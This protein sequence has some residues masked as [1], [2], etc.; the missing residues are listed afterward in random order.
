MNRVAAGGAVTGKSEFPGVFSPPEFKSVGSLRG[1][2]GRLRRRG[3]RRPLRG[4]GRR[5]VHRR[6]PDRRRVWREHRDGGS[7]RDRI[8]QVLRPEGWCARIGGILP[9]GSSEP[10]SHTAGT[11]AAN[12][13]ATA[14]SIS[15]PSPKKVA[16]EGRR[17]GTTSRRCSTTRLPRSYRQDVESERAPSQDVGDGEGWRAIAPT[18]G[19]PMS[20]EISTNM[21]QRPSDGDGAANRAEPVSRNGYFAATEGNLEGGGR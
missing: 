8:A 21:P 15:A 5:D 3:T 10:A 6:G 11:S 2:G 20:S 9:S 4:T 19:R 12:C 1:F 13:A 16:E 17:R 18:G 7:P 14:D